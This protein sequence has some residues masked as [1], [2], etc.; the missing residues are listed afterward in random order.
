[1]STTA[2]WG[3]RGGFVIDRMEGNVWSYTV[4]FKKEIETPE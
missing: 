2:R 3:L 1:M 4:R